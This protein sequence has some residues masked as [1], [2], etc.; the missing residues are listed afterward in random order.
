M[1]STYSIA[2]TPWQTTPPLL[3]VWKLLEFQIIISNLIYD[4]FPQNFVLA[5]ENE[6]IK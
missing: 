1:Y 4:T 5:V 3:A 2:Q 6:T